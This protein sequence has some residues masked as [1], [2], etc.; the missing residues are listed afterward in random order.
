MAAAMPIIAT[1]IIVSMSV[2]PVS[3]LVSLVL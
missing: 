2:K 3:E 1:T